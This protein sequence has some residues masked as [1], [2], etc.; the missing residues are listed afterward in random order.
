[1]KVYD[2]SRSFVT[3][4]MDLDQKP[5][6]M[7]SA[8]PPY[9]INQARMQLACVCT[10]EGPGFDG[11]RTYVLSESCKSEV[12]GAEADLFTRPN[13]DMCLIAD[14]CEFMVIKS[15]ASRSIH[16]NYINQG[17]AAQPERQAEAVED[18]TVRFNIYL[19]E[20]NARPLETI[21]DI[22]AATV[23]NHPLVARIEYEDQDHQICL[24]HPVK[25][26]NLNEVDGVYQTDTGPLIVPDLRR[27]RLE[28]NHRFIEV[29]DQAYA[30]FDASNWVDFIFNAPTEVGPDIFVNHYNVMRRVNNTRNT[31]YALRT[32]MKTIM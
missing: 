15:W 25:T 13:A 29:F 10:I 18:V 30:A 1:M 24:D 22:I 9:K 6:K 3:F 27:E 16:A 19:K 14:K 7:I 26:F 28:M 4:R 17:Q 11:A 23:Q 32:C 21:D 8:P 5:P 2:F 12:V 31:L 20:T